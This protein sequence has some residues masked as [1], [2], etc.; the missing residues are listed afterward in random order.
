MASLLILKIGCTSGILLIVLSLLGSFVEITEAK[1]DWI[2]KIFGIIYTAL[3]I[4]LVLCAF[5]LIWIA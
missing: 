4:I 2:W 1:D 3:W 5:L